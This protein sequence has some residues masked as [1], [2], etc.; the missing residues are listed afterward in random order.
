MS[1]QF[2]ILTLN[3]LIGVSARLNSTF[4]SV[5]KSVHSVCTLHQNATPRTWFL[6]VYTV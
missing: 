4:D 5:Q 3:R 1:Y 2:L 6:K